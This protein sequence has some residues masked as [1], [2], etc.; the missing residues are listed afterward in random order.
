MNNKWEFPTIK[1]CQMIPDWLIAYRRQPNAPGQGATHFFLD[2]FRFEAVWNNPEES[3]KHIKTQVV[4]SPDFSLYH[5][6]PLALQIWNTYRNRECG[7]YWQEKGL[8]VIPTVSWAGPDSY[9][10]CFTGIEPGGVVAVTTLG[11]QKNLAHRFGF[12]EGFVKMLELLKPQHILCYGELP[13][14]IKTNIKI[15]TYPTFWNK[16]GR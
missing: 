16:K 14:E 1:R 3:L 13:K 8:R 15:T 6:W 5:D 12:H 2:D 9:D 7:A 4:L 10:F 11:I